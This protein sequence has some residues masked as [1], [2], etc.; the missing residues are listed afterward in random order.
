MS[1]EKKVLKVNPLD[2]TFNNN[3]GKSKNNNTQKN[4]QNKQHQK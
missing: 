4:V 3:S 2:F 1:E